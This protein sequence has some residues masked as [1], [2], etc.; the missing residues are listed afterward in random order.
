ML[1][2]TRLRSAGAAPLVLLAASLACGTSGEGRSAPSADS[3][4]SQEA[5]SAVA[6]DVPLGWRVGDVDAGFD[7]V[8]LGFGG[9]AGAAAGI[10]QVLFVIFLVL[11]AVGLIAHLL[12]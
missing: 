2:A 11:F 12:R 5:G 6:C 10:A 8:A 3:V 4:L 7:R 1:T 9:I